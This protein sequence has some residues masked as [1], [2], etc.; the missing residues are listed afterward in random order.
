VRVNE[1]QDS[2]LAFDAEFLNI[3]QQID[4]HTYEPIPKDAS[5]KA[6]ERVFSAFPAWR[7][8]FDILHLPI[9]EEKEVYN[10]GTNSHE[11]PATSPLVVIPSRP[12]YGASCRR[13]IPNVKE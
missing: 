12:F 13:P 5:L 9:H 6:N 4:L 3:A 7:V 8:V 11:N 1:I 2:S 10:V